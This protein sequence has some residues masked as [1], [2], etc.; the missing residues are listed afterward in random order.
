MK[1]ANEE[2]A[3]PVRICFDLGHACSYDLKKP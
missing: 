1:E 2:A 3:V